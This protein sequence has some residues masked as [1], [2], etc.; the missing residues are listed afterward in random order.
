MFI[1]DNTAQQIETYGEIYVAWDETGVYVTSRSAEA[2]LDNLEELSDG[3]LRRVKKYIV[4]LFL[5][6]VEDGGELEPGI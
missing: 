5:P 3:R 2:A 4:P 6:V 1:D